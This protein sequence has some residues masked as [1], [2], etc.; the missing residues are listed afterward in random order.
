MF[1]HMFQ[2]MYCDAKSGAVSFGK[3]V[4]ERPF[5]LRSARHLIYPF[6]T[7]AV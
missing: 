4:A 6:N 1:P 3:V 2:D 5:P 7:D